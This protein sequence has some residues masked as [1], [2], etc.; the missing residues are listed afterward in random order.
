MFLLTE[1]ASYVSLI[2]QYSTLS[3]KIEDLLICSLIVLDEESQQQIDQLVDT[4]EALKNKCKEE[5]PS[6]KFRDV[7]QPISGKFLSMLTVES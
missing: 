2:Q 4:I 1:D 5:D 7:I 3:Q 6:L